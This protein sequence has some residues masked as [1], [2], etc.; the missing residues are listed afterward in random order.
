QALDVA[1]TGRIQANREIVLPLLKLQRFQGFLNSL[2]SVQVKSDE[3]LRIP[4]LNKTK[5]DRVAQRTCALIRDNLALK[6]QAVIPVRRIAKHLEVLFVRLALHKE[7]GIRAT[8]EHLLP[9][10]KLVSVE[11]QRVAERSHPVVAIRLDALGLP[12]LPIYRA[13]TQKDVR[14]RV[15]EV[16]QVRAMCGD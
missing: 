15:F 14:R 6:T 8:H 11:P 4:V 5:E 1:L 9:R 10:F 2:G 7:H 3:E 13:A 12:Q 16:Q